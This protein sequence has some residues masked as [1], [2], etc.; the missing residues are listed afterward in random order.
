ME[1]D[2][3]DQISPASANQDSELAFSSDNDFSTLSRPAAVVH[4][5]AV[6]TNGELSA[7]TPAVSQPLGLSD[8]IFSAA[9][10]RQLDA[11]NK[12]HSLG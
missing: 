3:S 10:R 11:I 5:N 4:P 2:L 12:L 9:R 6:P 1:S 8:P 7:V